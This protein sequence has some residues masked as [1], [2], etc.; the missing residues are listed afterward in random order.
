MGLSIA[1]LP[2]EIVTA[3]QVNARFIDSYFSAYKCSQSPAFTISIEDD[4][5]ASS[6]R[7]SERVVPELMPVSRTIWRIVNN[8]EQ[9]LSIGTIDTGSH[10]C[11]LKR[12]DSSN[13]YLLSSAIRLCVQ[14]FLERNEGFFLHGACGTIGT[15]GIL[16]TGKSTSGKSTAL[17]NLHPEKIVAEDAVALRRIDRAFKVY[18]IPF[19]G[20]KPDAATCMALCF[21][22]KW[23]GAPKLTQENESTVVAELTANALYCAPS[24]EELMRTVFSTIVECS[25]AVAGYNCYFAK[26][27]NLFSVFSDYGFFN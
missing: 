5:Q 4:T 1:D 3:Q 27:T 15:S 18:A 9:R 12:A 14:F 23:K 8:N 22:K 13:D 17:R 24:S 7:Y 11:L 25:G 16:F 21:P 20:E 19:R 2:F 10:R 6:E 26:S